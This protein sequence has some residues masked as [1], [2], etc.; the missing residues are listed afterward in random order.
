M[1]QHEFKGKDQCTYCHGTS[2][3]QSE[4]VERK[5]SYVVNGID[6]TF[7]CDCPVCH[8]IFEWED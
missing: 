6:E 8:Y 3:T 1:K 2:S 4:C 7:T 5:Q